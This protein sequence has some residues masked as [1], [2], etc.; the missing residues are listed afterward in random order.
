[1]AVSDRFCLT[2]AAVMSR[3]FYSALRN[4]KVADSFIRN[5]GGT[6]VLPSH[7]YTGAEEPFLVK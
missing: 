5:L 2:D 6:A 7:V 4:I 3:A 1:M